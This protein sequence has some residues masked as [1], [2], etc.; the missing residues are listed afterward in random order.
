MELLHPLSRQARS[1]NSLAIP[2]PTLSARHQHTMMWHLLPTSRNT[3]F[4]A[5]PQKKCVICIT[6]PP[7]NTNFATFP[8]A[9]FL[10]SL[11]PKLDFTLPPRALLATPPH[12]SNTHFVRNSNLQP[13]LRLAF[14]TLPSKGGLACQPNPS[15][16]LNSFQ[17][18]HRLPTWAGAKNQLVHTKTTKTRCILMQIHLG[19]LGPR[20]AK[21]SHKDLLTILPTSRICCQKALRLSTWGRMA[22]GSP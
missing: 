9:T 7:N 14:E 10:G 1:A 21:A 3:Y 15:A 18:Y 8:A 13:C 2:F 20:M 12:P 22:R 6:S 16:I 11:P 5:P 17:T 4:I 19:P